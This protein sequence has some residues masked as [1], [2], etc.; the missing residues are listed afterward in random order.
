MGEASKTKV[1]TKEVAKPNKIGGVLTKRIGA[2]TDAGLGRDVTAPKWL[3]AI[4]GYFKGSYDE[5]RQV[6]WPN[7]RATWSLT[8]AV[9]I[10]TVVFVALILGLDYAFDQLFKKVIL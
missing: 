9:I 2:K 3:R 8:F 7:R 4:G 5:L 10:F 6:K 1:K